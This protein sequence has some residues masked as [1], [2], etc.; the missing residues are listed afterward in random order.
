M[1]DKLKTLKS[2]ADSLK[3]GIDKLVQ[4]LD[5]LLDDEAQTV[6]LDTI[7]EAGLKTPTEID[8]KI[9]RGLLSTNEL[10]VAADETH[11]QETVL[12]S[13][14][15]KTKEGREYLMR[16]RLKKEIG[17]EAVEG[18]GHGAFRRSG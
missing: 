9:E 8:L 17:K 11:N 4:D 10:K 7:L 12:E 18:T 2:Q 15:E 3:E 16:F 5:E 1:N 14:L 6:G 13:E